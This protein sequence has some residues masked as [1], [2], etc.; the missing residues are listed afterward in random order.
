MNETTAQ[1]P[2]ED[3]A[4]ALR[5]LREIMLDENAEDLVPVHAT[6]L[7]LPLPDLV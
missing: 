2:D 3:E 1:T 5:V 7:R 4:L 6:L